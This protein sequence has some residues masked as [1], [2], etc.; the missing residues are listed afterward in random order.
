MGMSKLSSC[1][2]YEAAQLV[3]HSEADSLRSESG[4]G[5]GGL[6]SAVRMIQ[7][8]FNANDVLIVEPVRPPHE[9]LEMNERGC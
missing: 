6:L 4:G 3:R 9:A 8:G 5:F 7:N 1:K 2:S